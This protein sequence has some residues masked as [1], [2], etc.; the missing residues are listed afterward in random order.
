MGI[1]SS[2][3]EYTTGTQTVDDKIGDSYD[4]VKNVEEHL[5]ELLNV[6][7]NIDD[8]E[9][10]VANLAAIDGFV[11]AVNDGV[12]DAEAA[13]VLSAAS[14]VQSEANATSSIAAKVAAEL[15]ETNAEA[16]RDTAIT[17]AAEASASEIA[18][19]ADR[20]AAAA[21]AAA[22][23]VSAG[24][25]G[26]AA[27]QTAADRVAT[28]ADA[29]ATDLDRIATAADRAATGLDVIAAEADRVATAADRVQTGLDVIAAE[30]DRVA[31][32]ADRVAVESAFDAAI[33]ATNDDAVATAADRIQTG[34][35]RIATGSDKAGT[36]ADRIQTGLD[37]VATA[38]DRVQT[39]ADVLSTVANTGVSTADKNAAAISAD[40]AEAAAAGALVT[41]G[42]MDT[43]LA[44]VTDYSNTLAQLSPAAREVVAAADVVDVFIYDTTLDSDGGAWR[45]RCNWTSWMKETLSTAIRGARNQFPQKALLVLRSAGTDN[46]SLTIYDMDQASCPLWMQFWAASTLSGSVATLSAIG[47]YVANGRPTSVAM[48]N[49]RLVVGDLANGISII[50]FV[51]DIAW[52][53]TSAYSIHPNGVGRSIA[54]R[55]L[56]IGGGSTRL[57]TSGT[58]IVNNF[59]NDVALTVPPGTP[60]DRVRKLP[61]P[62]VAVAT[63]GGVSVI[64]W[65]GRVANSSSTASFNRATFGADGTLFFAFVTTGGIWF[66]P[67]EE[68][69]VTGFI[70][71][72]YLRPA[73]GSPLPLGGPS[74]GVASSPFRLFNGSSSG[75][76]VLHHRPGS[77]IRSGFQIN[78]SA[79]AYIT[80]KYSTGY[81]VGDS[82]LAL[83]ESTADV[84]SMVQGATD[85]VNSAATEKLNNGDFAGGSTSWAVS[86]E[87][88]THIA[89]FSG[90]TL[91][92]QSDTTS[93]ILNIQQGGAMTF[94]RRYRAIVVC[95]SYTSG[96]IKE[97]SGAVLCA[98]PGTTTI[99]FTATTSNFQIQRNSTNVDLTIDSIS[100]KELVTTVFYDDF[101]GYADTAAMLAAGWDK[102][103]TSLGTVT[104]VSGEFQFQRDASGAISSAAGKQI[105]NFVVGVRYKI[106][107]RIRSV[108]AGGAS[109]Q[110]RTSDGGGGSS[111]ALSDNVSVSTPTTVTINW[112]ADRTTAHIALA[113]GSLTN[114]AGM[115]DI[116][117]DVA[118]ND[119][120]VAANHPLVY[121]TVTRTAVA[122]GAELA[123]YGG[124][125]ASS[126]LETGAAA[127]TL[128]TGDFCFSAWAYYGTLGGGL[129]QESLF[130]VLGTNELNFEKQSGNSSLRVNQSGRFTG[131]SST[132]T[133]ISNA[134]NHV[135]F[136]RSGTNM[137]YYINGVLAGTSTMPSYDGALTNGTIRIGN[138]TDGTS[139]HR[140]Q[141]ALAR[142][143]LT[144]PTPQ[145]IRDM[146]AAELP[147]FQA[148]AK[149]LL[150]SDS[151]SALAYDDS[152]D[153]LHVATPSGMAR[154]RD[155]LVVDKDAIVV[156]GIDARSG[157]VVT[158]DTGSA[159][160]TQPSLLMRA[161]ML[162]P[163]MRTPYDRDR[164]RGSGV[165]INATPTIIGRI[166]FDKGEHRLVDVRVRANQYA[167]GAAYGR[168]VR[169]ALIDRPEE[170]NIVLGGS[171]E[172]VGTDGE[173][174]GTQ[175]ISVAVNTTTQT[176]DITATGLASTNI[177]WN[178]EAVLS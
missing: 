58:K 18:A 68:Y 143:G 89:T 175:D 156:T 129:S 123:A 177:E 74:T 147:L 152:T 82:K 9:V 167:D 109:L 16:A 81:M 70:D 133:L 144:A 95:S 108:T 155:L 110:L 99:D 165:T 52:K 148:N 77:G 100:L 43:A 97:G 25:I 150:P 76:D 135:A 120:S 35:D 42:L 20:V 126:Y 85:F 2:L 62:T 131:T 94:G 83:A 172:T 80:S 78:S 122:T 168:Y 104:L 146:Y 53:S 21:S 153:L 162:Q 71:R 4:V 47:S 98:G 170:G 157:I 66:S 174:T 56:Q 24:S 145:Q 160:V 102:R 158:R 13:A 3:N 125:S 154:L 65:D 26:A 176:L 36:A 130:T 112:V 54:D 132:G 173:G 128:G 141:I 107:A 142:A 12:D 61:T 7:S 40:E 8:I 115:E 75:L 49:G 178:W 27:I 127:I 64:H 50:D 59:V 159:D 31:V 84:T 57:D 87:D 19:E 138:R 72:Y 15:A 63:A 32:A 60:V 86:G 37:V 17:K 46:G 111:L 151:V 106:T 29:A 161:E 149:C 88:A 171:V 117:I 48:L 124:F 55:N 38:A 169:R 121:G 11:A 163:D 103:P 41:K 10:I 79:I 5:A 114:V 23:A 119:R 166:P 1:R 69:A 91:R 93:P 116:R 113:P 105:S 14:A 136:V 22:A 33:E 6:N 28:G 51:S 44:G 134:W 30:A 73:G 96:S 67:R 90:G 39:G 137:N 118:A 164:V 34:L 92:Y 101:G 45:K 140:Q 139:N